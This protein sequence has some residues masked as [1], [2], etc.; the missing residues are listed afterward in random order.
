[1]PRLPRPV[2]DGLVYHAIKRGNNRDR[3]FADA[4]DFRALP[5][6]PA[7]TQARYP[8]RLSTG[9]PF[10]AAGWSEATAARPGLQRSG[11][12]RGRPRKNRMA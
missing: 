3:V 7:R 10:G 12:P 1:M 9:R 2:A 5:R 11:R 6:A 8:F 4:E